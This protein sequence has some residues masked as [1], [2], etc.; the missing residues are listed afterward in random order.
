MRR[1]GRQEGAQMAITPYLLYEDVSGALAFL[2]KAFGFQRQDKPIVGP[3][4]KVNHAAMKFGED[5][6]M[7]GCPGS[8]YRNPKRLG[9]ATQS[10][11][12]NVPNVD[13]H[14]QRA[15]AAGATNIEE[16]TNTFYGHRRYGAEDLEGIS[17]TSLRKPK[18]RNPSRDE[19]RIR[20]A[21][22]PAN[23]CGAQRGEAQ[24]AAS[25]RE[26][27]SPVSQLRDRVRFTGT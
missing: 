4:G 27:N 11:Y 8:D 23:R 12:I 10:L 26:P 20:D 25:L 9:Q 22:A 2:S 21:E 24:A 1:F 16:P 19:S 15:R 14:F 5:S 7:M 17:G 13:E 6:I 3:D 18:N